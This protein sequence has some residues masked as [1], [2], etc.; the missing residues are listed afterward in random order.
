MGWKQLKKK[1]YQISF[2]AVNVRYRRELRL[3]KSYHIETR[4]LYWDELQLIVEQKFVDP[5]TEFVHTIVYGKYVLVR[6]GK[7]VKHHYLSMSDLVAEGLH[8]V[9]F[10]EHSAMMDGPEDQSA[11]RRMVR[12]TSSG[13]LSSMNGIS[14][15]KYG[16]SYEEE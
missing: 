9:Q 4:P 11:P 3:F 8:T 16:Q 6:N 2:V 14:E 1:Q 10:Y 12:V 13:S 5:D 15:E 7:K